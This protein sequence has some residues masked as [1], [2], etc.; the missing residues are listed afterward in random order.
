MPSRKPLSHEIIDLNQHHIYLVPLSLQECIDFN[1]NRPSMGFIN[2]CFKWD[3]LGYRRVTQVEDV[4]VRAQT[5]QP[6]TEHIA[7]LRAPMKCF[8]GNASSYVIIMTKWF[9]IYQK[10]QTLTSWCRCWRECNRS[11]ATNTW[12]KGQY[13]QSYQHAFLFGRWQCAH[14]CCHMFRTVR[15]LQRCAWSNS[16]IVW[17]VDAMQASLSQK[18]WGRLWNYIRMTQELPM[19]DQRSRG[20]RNIRFTSLR[21]IKCFPAVPHIKHFCKNRVLAVA[22]FLKSYLS[23]AT[24]LRGHCIECI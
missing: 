22:L 17:H 11:A 6:V 3:E 10:C 12:C 9:F 8:R 14:A 16:S 5:K 21:W 4:H 15:I 13:W 24:A 20:W 19:R 7:R 2:L 18:T 1:H 23:R